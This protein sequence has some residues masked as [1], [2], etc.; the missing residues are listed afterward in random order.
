MERIIKIFDTTLRDGEQSP[1]ASM[2]IKQKIEVA[3]QLK[4]LNVDIIEAGFPIC[5]PGDFESVKTIA[6]QIKGPVICGL[7]RALEKDIARCGEAIKSATN[8]V[9][10]MMKSPSLS[11]VAL[12]PALSTAVILTL[13]LEMSIPGT[14]VHV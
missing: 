9:E 10:S 11:S 14:G 4:R 1:G 13:T 5:S 7:A 3:N 12:F 8:G 6:E 2:N